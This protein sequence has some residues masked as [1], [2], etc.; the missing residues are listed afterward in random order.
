MLMPPPLILDTCALRDKAFRHWLI[1]Y[2]QRK[3]LPVVA[4]ME[5]LVYF[6]GKKN[7]RQDE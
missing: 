5:L 6:I 7:K 4:Y 1:T 2:H 3:V